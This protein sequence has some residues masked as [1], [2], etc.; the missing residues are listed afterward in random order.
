M[1]KRYYETLYYNSEKATVYNVA[2]NLPTTAHAAALIT[3]QYAPCHLRARNTC[4]TLQLH[5]LFSA[6]TLKADNVFPLLPHGARKNTGPSRPLR[7]TIPVR[8]ETPPVSKGRRGLRGVLIRFRLNYALFRQRRF[9]EF[10]ARWR[11]GLLRSGIKEINPRLFSAGANETRGFLCLI[12]FGFLG[13]RK[14]RR[15]NIWDDVR[16]F[17]FRC[18]WF[19]LQ[20]GMRGSWRWL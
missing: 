3:K 2:I 17:R 19:K 15:M 6:N 1:L 4:H 8:S 13:G 18:F 9:D 14:R 11:T 12:G 16:R 20:S 10:S 7:N 5:T